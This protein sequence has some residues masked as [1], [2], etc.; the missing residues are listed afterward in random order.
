MIITRAPLRI[1][2]SGGGSD[3]PMHFE[4]FGGAVLSA[5]INKYVY[6][7]I[8]PFF[9]LNRVQLKYSSTEN[10][11]DPRLIR[12][13]IFRRILEK[14]AL[15]GVELTS[16]ADIPT[17]TGLGSSSSFTVALL[18]T[19]HAYLKQFR[20]PAQLA[21]EACRVEIDDL[22]NPIGK[23]DQY[24]AALGGLSYI[25]FHQD[26]SVETFPVSMDA[27]RIRELNANLM[28]FFTGMSRDANAILLD[29]TANLRADWTRT[30]KLR[31]IVVI[32]KEM[33]ECL[34]TNQ[35]DRFGA[36]LHETWILKKTLANEISNAAID[37][38][39]HIA[40][41]AGAIGG[42]LLGAGAG[43][44]LLLY[45]TREWQPEVRKALSMLRETK[46]SFESGG[47][48]VVYHNE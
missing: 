13:R 39:Y 37:S 9:D 45:C 48:R 46:F 30:E 20:S 10:V 34:E 26:G 11:D 29:Q 47:V 25:E 2:F 42:K 32:A 23:Q 27:E 44:F 21:D 40:R 22:G 24:A 1:S 12:H 41:S 14:Y 38:Y 35:L 17:G 28:L 6:V 19:V 4:K 3:L 16:T 8:H 43:G 15:N 36:L 18:Q 33:R 5:T 7:E 31:R